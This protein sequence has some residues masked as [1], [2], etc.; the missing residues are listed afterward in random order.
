MNYSILLL[1]ALSLSLITT[2]AFLLLSIRKNFIRGQTFRI[3]FLDRI[4]ATRFGKMMKKHN[5][6]P[7]GL[8]HT[9]PISGIVN[10]IRICRDCVKTTECNRIL[11]KS[12][13][14]EDDLAFCPNH[15]SISQQH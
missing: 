6:D 2:A 1:C 10:Q 5:V 8:V 11:T 14:S 7:Q 9:Q 4:V 13:V 12:V 15:L 3:E